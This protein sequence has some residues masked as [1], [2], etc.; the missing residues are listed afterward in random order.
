MPEARAERRLAA[1]LA[2][3]VAGY[4]RLMGAD[5]EGTLQNLKAHRREVI[6]P[7]I[8][9][10]RG[11]IVKNIGD[12][13]LV[14]FAS[15]VDAVRCALEIQIAMALR[16]ADV[17]QERRIEFRIGINVGDI[18]IDEGDIY[19]DGVNIA[20]RLETLAKPGSICI[21]D[22]AYR[23]IEDKIAIS[24]SDLG[25]QHLKNI[26]R[27]V[28]AFDVLLDG[29]PPAVAP[30]LAL[31]DTPSIAVLPFQNM[32][33]DAEQEYFADGIVEDITTALSK[34]RWIFVVSRNSAF[35]Y[36][37]KSI[38][39]KQVARE[40]GV[41]Y[42]LEG[43]VRK[44]GNRVRITTQ[45]VHADSGHHVWADHYDREIEDIFA[46]QDEITQRV[47]IEVDP[48]LRHSELSRIA[49][50]PPENLHAW[51]HFLRG[52]AYFYAYTKLEMIQAREQFEKAIALDPNFAAAHARLAMAH[53]L[54]AANAWSKTFQISLD[55]ACRSAKQGVS[56]DDHDSSAHVALSYSLL[57]G[58]QYDQSLS[59][60]R[61]AV[62]VNSNFFDAHFALAI[63]LTYGGHPDEALGVFEF[64]LRLSPYDPLAWATYGIFAMA[65]YLVGRY[66]E[67]ISAA[68]KSMRLRPRYVTGCAIRAAGLAQL[69]KVSEAEGQLAIIPA[70]SLAKV[71]TLWPFR[72]DDD[73]QRV[74]DGLRKAGLPADG[75]TSV[76]NK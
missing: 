75:L 2:A 56:L 70:S 54:E 11:R 20:A 41:R 62:E 52:S 65:L 8:A 43:S 19:G 28:R 10:H 74:F 16:N 34:L 64:A 45:L 72:N 29:R 42:L 6:D 24:V 27:A 58:R 22:N 12:G 21:A 5:E 40:L 68:E 26:S 59:A 66:E 18:M 44:V 53:T 38:D 39:V 48:A 3:D 36:K 47:V 63:S 15:A 32:S 33:G 71:V 17:P 9:G 23:Q 25:E 4:S 37:G 57:Y 1:I 51:D 13:A 31:P 73:L 14:E 61:R 7:C 30:P 35:I 76:Q 69:G 46:V 55:A 49:R 60:A 50:K 67:A